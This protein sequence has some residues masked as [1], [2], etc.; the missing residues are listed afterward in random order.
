M[1]ANFEL[2]SPVGMR[3]YGGM[4]CRRCSQRVPDFAGFCPRCGI[5]M[6]RI[7]RDMFGVTMFG[8]G[9]TVRQTRRKGPL[10]LILCGIG[11]VLFFGA[12]FA[13]QSTVPTK[14]SIEIQP[15]G[16]STP[17]PGQT[18]SI[19]FVQPGQPWQPRSSGEAVIE[20]DP[21]GMTPEQAEVV[22]RELAQQIHNTSR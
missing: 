12:L 16:D 5:A 14:H 7:D 22:K 15:F 21:K 17:I 8:A 20:F 6:R 11:A 18:P 13:V 4:T 9:T 1:P 19:R 10:L 3:H 2:Q